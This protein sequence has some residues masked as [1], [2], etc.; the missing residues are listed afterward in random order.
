MLLSITR[1]HSTNTCKNSDALHYSLPTGLSMRSYW[2]KGCFIKYTR[3][4]YY[5]VELFC[6]KIVKTFPIILV[7]Y[8]NSDL[9]FFPFVA[10]ERFSIEQRFVIVK[11]LYS[12][13]LYCFGGFI[14]FVLKKLHTLWNTLYYCHMS[15]ELGD[16]TAK[17][18]KP[19]F[20]FTLHEYINAFCLIVATS[21]VAFSGKKG[22]LETDIGK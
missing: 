17:V 11:T 3:F 20:T 14:A 12:L 6:L 8:F 5:F 4:F 2:G 22:S 18:W 1:M 13:H 7:I 15:S 21:L 9:S 19:E 16:R 10:I